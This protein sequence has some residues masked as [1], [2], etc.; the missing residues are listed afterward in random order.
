M[1]THLVSLKISGGKKKR[2]QW[3]IEA[4]PIICPISVKRELKLLIYRH[5]VS[6]RLTIPF[7]KYATCK[8][9]TTS[10]FALNGILLITQCFPRP[11]LEVPVFWDWVSMLLLHFC[12][13]HSLYVRKIT[14]LPFHL[15]LLLNYTT[16][17]IIEFLPD[18]QHLGWAQTSGKPTKLFSL[19]FSGSKW[20]M[21]KLQITVSLE[22]Q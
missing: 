4:A 9:T 22:K 13:L 14:S 18:G 20:T 10:W 1:E 5:L 16:K 3:L 17:T 7:N 21:S 2:A 6:P 19:T 8:M 12:S 15:D 11:C